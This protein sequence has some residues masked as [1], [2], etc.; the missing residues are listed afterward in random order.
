M[1]IHG[2]TLTDIAVIDLATPTPDTRQA[3]LYL[4]GTACYGNTIRNLRIDTYPITGPISGTGVKHND[5]ELEAQWGNV[6]SI[7]DTGA[8][9]SNTFRIKGGATTGT[10][11]AITHTGG[12]SR[13][14]DTRKGMTNGGT[15]TLTGD[16]TTTVFTIAHGLLK[17]PAYAI[18][19]AGNALTRDNPFW[20]SWGG[21]SIS[22]NFT[23]PPANGLVFR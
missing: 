14:I 13:I 12:I 1:P 10:A 7:T 22:V 8:N 6:A 19:V 11:T 5:I 23:T 17:T 15:A 2:N 3:A 20:I 18:V 16:G 21:V 9:A 4:A